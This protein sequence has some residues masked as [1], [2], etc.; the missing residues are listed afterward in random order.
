MFLYK[1]ERKWLNRCG[2]IGR[3]SVIFVLLVARYDFVPLLYF[4]KLN[5]FSILE[6]NRKSGEDLFK[7]IGWGNC[8]REE[9]DGRALL[10][11]KSPTTPA[12]KSMQNVPH[13]LLLQNLIDFHLQTSTRMINNCDF[14]RQKFSRLFVYARVRA[15][16][17]RGSGRY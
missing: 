13:I 5:V 3:S 10:Y 11:D 15:T 4:C 17:G 12:V 16:R 8:T 9:D 2:V 7:I 6:N 1:T 14:L